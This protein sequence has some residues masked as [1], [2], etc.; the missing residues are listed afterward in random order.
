MTFR[1]INLFWPLLALVAAPLLVHLF[2]RTRPPTMRFSSVIFLR[3]VVRNTMRVRKPRDILVLIL[4]TL[5]VLA[6]I[7]MVLRPI[8][9]A[10]G[11]WLSPGAQRHVVVVVDRSAS[12]GYNEGG[13][14]RFAV[15]CT[16]A[17]D[18]LSG[19]S[20][21]DTANIVWIDAAP[22]PVFPDMGVNFGFLRDT[23]R[24]ARVS[25]QSGSVGAA[26]QLAVRLLEDHEGRREIHLIS[27]FQHTAWS[28]YT[29]KLPADIAFYAIHS[30][31]AAA[32]NVAIT[33]LRT[34]PL[35]GLP[36]ETVDV[37]AEVSNFSD[38]PQHAV[39]F[40]TFGE[41]R[42]KQDIVIPAW[43]KS[44]LLFRHTPVQKGDSVLSATLEA[45]GD[46]FADDNRRY[47]VLPVRDHL[48]VGVPEG[49]TPETDRFS[50]AL[51]SLPWVRIL[52]LPASG[53]SG[54]EM[55]DVA[56]LPN[57]APDDVRLRI[58]SQNHVMVIWS[59]P[60]GT[61]LSQLGPFY[62][63]HSEALTVDT[64]RPPYRL[65]IVSPHDPALQI[66]ADGRYGDPAAG[67]VQRR[68]TLPPI[69]AGAGNVLIAYHDGVPAIVRASGKEH[70][71][72]W[73]LPLDPKRSD[74]TDQITF[75]PFIGELLL[76]H[77][78]RAG[79]GLSGRLFTSGDHVQ[80]QFAAA[81]NLTDI[82][83]TDRQDQPL[84][85]HTQA[86]A[87]GPPRCVSVVTPEP[88][89]FTW[90]DKLRV[91]GHSVVNFPSNESD[92]RMLT[93]AEVKAMGAYQVSDARTLRSLHSGREIWHLLL[94][95]GL[96]VLIVE[97]IVLFIFERKP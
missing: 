17:S 74:V 52:P 53:N 80:R 75:V 86:S 8:F 3:R 58:L 11:R 63:G 31:Q 51:R 85:L 13:R 77:R 72:L 56:F 4:R 67:T 25:S 40:M 26:I 34:Q 38:V 81:R 33:D 30:A 60:Q 94:I 88:G 92:L 54:L 65:K 93:Q 45:N 73:N 6:L 95:G 10:D 83:L 36:D 46:S 22:D 49:I 7:L 47:H 16:E 43:E 14:T 20:T 59:P 69:P 37:I 2:A 24:K 19:L 68:L 70:L 64:A 57:V 91:L 27:D 12:M 96:I 28:Q 84:E 23:L 1:F 87:D 5:A 39:L 21:R 76:S 44:T 29:P 50:R 79:Y 71:I 82:Q 48:T 89:V 90:R 32:A 62:A 55:P 42:E 97:A 78:L 66:F 41:S 61:L 9:F 35:R 18:I 15:A